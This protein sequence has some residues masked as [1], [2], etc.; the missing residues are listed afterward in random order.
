MQGINLLRDKVLLGV[1]KI[2]TE[3]LIISGKSNQEHS[4]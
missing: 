4:I 2:G 1:E 3:T